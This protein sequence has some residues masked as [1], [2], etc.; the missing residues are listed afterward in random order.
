MPIIASAFL[1][2]SPL[3][4]PEIGKQNHRLLKKTTQAYQAVA[5]ILKAEEVDIILVISPNGPTRPDGL[6]L[7]IGPTLNLSFQEFGYLA[8]IKSFLPA[9]S[10]ADDLKAQLGREQALN[11][12]SQRELDYGT[13]VPLQLL[14]ENLKAIKI[15]PL[16]PAE[17]LDRRT[18][19]LIG[20]E[21]GT[22]L[23]ARPEKIA[24]IAAGDLSHR[25]KKKSPAGYTPKG[26]RFDNRVIEYL[27]EAADG[28]EKLLS[29]D[30]KLT[31]EVLEGGLKQL[32]ILLGIIGDTYEP[33][34]LAY[35][36]D[37]G[38]GY[39]SVNFNLKVAPI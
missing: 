23:R 6:S 17:N 30:E 24:V 7:N 26:A 19:Y 15:L 31:E 33:E 39:L 12:I 21:I 11:F 20:Q 14:T 13:A 1:P 28:R 29:I 35:Q 34:I 3:L 5:D 22:V 18:H 4:I 38:V 9:L 37:F 36:T 2:P 8:T 27:G 10:L 32:A 25:L 16:F